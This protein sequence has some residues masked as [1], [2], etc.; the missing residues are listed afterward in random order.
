M[1]VDRADENNDASFMSVQLKPPSQR[2]AQRALE[3]LFREAGLLE[4]RRRRRQ[5]LVAM[6]A[7]AVLA[8]VSYLVARST[9]NP[10][11]AHRGERA[12][13]AGQ[14]LGALVVPE[15][16]S[17]LA[18]GADGRLYVADDTRNEILQWSR[19]GTFRVIAGT[20]RA[21]FSGDGGEALDAQ[22]DQPGGMAVAADGTLYFA[23]T[24]N[25]RI[26]AISP[27]GMITTVAG[28]ARPPRDQWVRSGTNALKAA[29]GG[30]NDVA[31]GPRGD[32]YFDDS[33]N[34]VLRLHRNGTLSIVVGNRTAL[35]ISGIGGPASEAS[36][37]EPAGLAFDSVGD[38]FINGS[39]TR[40]LLM[41]TPSGRITLPIGR[42]S[43][44]PRG[45]GGMITTATGAVVAM[46]DLAIVRLS[47]HAAR[48][49][50][51]LTHRIARVGT[52]ELNGIAPA[53]DGGFYADTSRGNGF[54][55]ANALAEIKPDG[56]LQL[57]WTSAR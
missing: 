19:R 40:K 55:R 49:V 12:S 36:P 32:L 50:V 53:P 51:S 38:L 56:R 20:G 46:D 4:R 11:G 17:S 7:C 3:A 54:A 26:R 22:L 33:A 42:T 35:A 44:Y 34:E 27:T 48:I 57:L 16:P 52:F 29:L 14:P 30:P 37:D 24:G 39:N 47:P 8:A 6:L 25:G 41:V 13:L 31:I 1:G 10:T 21:G 23:D 45:P 43:F 2:R 15:R 5:A 18:V 28:D 9:D